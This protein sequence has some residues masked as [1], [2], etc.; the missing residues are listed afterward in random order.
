M[1]NNKITIGIKI[2]DITKLS[3]LNIDCKFNLREEV[4][5]CYCNL[6]HIELDED[7][8]CFWAEGEEDESITD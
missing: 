2:E 8:K 5:A 7:G 6:K 3:C 1:P 4:G